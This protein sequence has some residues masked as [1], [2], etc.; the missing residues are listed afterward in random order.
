M[1]LAGDSMSSRE[2][3]FQALLGAMRD[4]GFISDFLQQQP[5]SSQDYQLAHQIAYGACRMRLSLDEI[6]RQ[7]SGRPTLQLK[8]RERALLHTALY[9]CY[10]MDRIPLYAVVN[11]SVAIAKKLG[12][13]AFSSFL[14]A[15]LRNTERKKTVLPSDNSIESLAIRYSY[16]PFLVEQF[17]NA[18][19]LQE[20]Q[21]IME[22][23]NAPGITTARTRARPWKIIQVE[24]LFAIANSP[25][26]YIQN[27]TPVSLLEHLSIT[28]ASPRSIL[29][30]CSA[31]GG[32]LIAAH[33][34]YPRAELFANDLTE[35]KLTLLRENLSKYNISATLT[36]GP[37]QEYP[38]NQ[39]FDLIIV[40]AP[41]SNS[42]VLNKRPEARWRLTSETL[43]EQAKQQAA[44][45][46]HAK[47]LLSPQGQIWYM[48]CSILPE[49]NEGVVGKVSG[50]KVVAEKTVL[51]SIDGWDGGFGCVLE[52]KNM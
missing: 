23:M 52:L 7:L 32:K 41:C 2:A 48:T 15:I 43:H 50:M 9:Q 3:A 22:A 33:D 4:E 29:D 38:K 18:F 51:P 40:D 10:Y 21:S 42:G 39:Q 28:S 6:A 11:E 13:I 34:L 8:K 35:S 19:G 30:L 12:N 36:Y 31:P 24:D 26:Y 45:L 16:P 1:S 17:L 44:L 14:N 47:T 37:G 46:E 25:D 49:E 27:A 5:L 20:A